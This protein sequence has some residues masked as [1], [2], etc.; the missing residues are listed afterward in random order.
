[1]KLTE[2]ILDEI[3]NQGSEIAKKY[4]V[5][6]LVFDAEK[7]KPQTATG[8]LL[9]TQRGTVLVTSAHVF[10][11]YLELKDA[12]RFQAGMRGKVIKN[13][14]DR[15]RLSK[16]QDVGFALLTDDEVAGTGF[17]VYPKSG[18][19]QEPP[20]KLD[21]VAYSGFPGCWKEVLANIG[22]RLTALTC[23]AAVETV[24][25]DQFSVRM[26]EERYELAQNSIRHLED[27]G[28]ISGAP[29][30]S[31][32]DFWKSKR[33]QPLL[34]GFIFEGYVWS[35]TDHKHYAVPLKALQEIADFEF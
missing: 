24:E 29:V 31:L 18:V 6:L 21:L 35:E 33:R 3:S 34:I 1:M 28:G 10:E 20:Q 16:T 15:I 26:D 27:A 32:F 7:T 11:G 13:L 12:G 14:K 19:S 8:L 4:S 9:E 25:D 22:M 5:P 30:F 17:P 23:L 2:K